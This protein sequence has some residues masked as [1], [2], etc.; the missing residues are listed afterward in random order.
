MISLQPAD[1]KNADGNSHVAYTSHLLMYQ[2]QT[3]FD[4]KGT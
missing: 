4:E 3:N 1:Q 2:A